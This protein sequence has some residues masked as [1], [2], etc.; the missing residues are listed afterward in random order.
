MG[1][2][3]AELY[4]LLPHVSTSWVLVAAGGTGWSLPY[5]QAEGRPRLVPGLASREMSRLLGLSVI[6]YRHARVTSDEQNQ[7]QEGIFLHLML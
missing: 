1:N 3:T 6:A 4:G 7:H 5:V 2:W